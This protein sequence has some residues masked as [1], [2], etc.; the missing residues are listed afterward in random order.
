MLS[1]NR[2]ESSPCTFIHICRY[3]LHAQLCRGKHSRIN[4]Y[5][6]ACTHT[7]VC[8][9]I[10]TKIYARTRACTHIHTHAYVHTWAHIHRHTHTSARVCMHSQSPLSR[11]AMVCPCMCVFTHLGTHGVACTPHVGR[12]HAYVVLFNLGYGGQQLTLPQFTG[13]LT[14]TCC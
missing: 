10:D 12:I 7:Y 3:V 5:A 2:P 14:L 13:F 8:G 11:H 4:I 1:L 9:H 6:Q